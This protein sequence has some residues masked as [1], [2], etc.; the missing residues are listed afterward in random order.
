MYAE[1]SAQ[2]HLYRIW[3]SALVRKALD[4]VIVEAAVLDRVI[5]RIMSKTTT[6]D[7]GSLLRLR[8]YIRNS[9]CL[10]VPANW[11]QFCQDVLAMVIESRE[12]QDAMLSHVIERI[13]NQEDN[14]IGATLEEDMQNPLFFRAFRSA[15]VGDMVNGWVKTD[16]GWM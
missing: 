7:P 16:F 13:V 1:K 14:P 5:D 4:N 8:K 11:E 3:T 2:P 6:R 15:R 10:N 9:R 12:A